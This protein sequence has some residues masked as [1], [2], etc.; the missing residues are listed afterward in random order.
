MAAPIRPVQKAQPKRQ[1][2]PADQTIEVFVCENC[3]GSFDRIV[4]R[5]RKP[6]NCSGWRRS[7]RTARAVVS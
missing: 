5:G 2:A 6:K 3:C 4:T 1:A 7:E